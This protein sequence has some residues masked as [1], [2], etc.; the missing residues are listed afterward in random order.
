MQMTHMKNKVV[1]YK[2][3]DKSSEINFWLKDKFNP[4]ELLLFQFEQFDC[5]FTIE[6]GRMFKQV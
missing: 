3:Y 5:L 6:V 1:V 4:T 2:V